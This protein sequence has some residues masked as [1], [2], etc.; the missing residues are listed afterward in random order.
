M[1]A[2]TLKPNS[3]FIMKRY[4]LTS[5][6][7]HALSST[8]LQISQQPQLNR[9]FNIPLSM[10]M[11]P[12]KK[13]SRNHLHSSLL[14]NLSQLIQYSIDLDFLKFVL[15]YIRRLCVELTSGVKL[16]FTWSSIQRCSTCYSNGES[17]SFESLQLITLHNFYATFHALIEYIQYTLSPFLELWFSNEI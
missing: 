2:H 3:F 13:C 15:L 7:L 8:T 5:L 16:R 11:I 10:V 4:D 17:F 12:L 1:S 9:I 14:S 6:V